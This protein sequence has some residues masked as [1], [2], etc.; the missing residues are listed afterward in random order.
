MVQ[1]W[2]PSGSPRISDPPSVVPVRPGTRPPS[3]RTT[4]CLAPQPHVSLRSRA[5]PVAHGAAQ[6]LPLRH[7]RYPST[8][9]PP[10]RLV[11]HPTR[12]Q[13]LRP[14]AATNHRRAPRTTAIR[15]PSGQAGA[16]RSDQTRGA[17][18]LFQV[19]KKGHLPQRAIMLGRGG[20]VG[21]MPVY[22]KT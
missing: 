15:C 19:P 12:P 14:P 21:M 5:P 16:V 3:N 11:T 13:D 8:Q 22:G 1:A 2:A 4:S 9:V 20:N 17:W 18:C 7:S 6:R 10:G